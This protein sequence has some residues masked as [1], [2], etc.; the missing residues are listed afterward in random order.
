MGEVYAAEDVVAE[1]MVALKVMR[2]DS[3]DPAAPERFLREAQAL[4]RVRS[5]HVVRVF[6]FDRDMERALLFVAME[7]VDGEDLNDLLAHGRLPPSLVVR[8]M[9]DVA[10]ALEVTHGAGIIHRDLK[11]SNLKLQARPDGSVRVK[12]LDFGL[13]RDR[14]SSASLTDMGKAPGTLTYMPPEILDEQEPDEQSDVYSLGVI[15]YEMLAGRPPFQGKTRVEIAIKH[16]R[17]QP[18]WIEHLVPEEI[19]DGLAD[20]IHSMLVK[21]PSK[22]TS[23]AR[24]VRLE[25]TAIRKE[26]ELAYR[27]GGDGGDGDPAHDWGLLPHVED[28]DG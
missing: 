7:L 4:A 9:E 17:D 25:A 16:L 23:S 24:M 14:W 2:R 1:R 21:D 18:R 13:V 8:V 3:D 6:D 22:R 5:P 20:L 12:L 19:P 27:V 26:N 11:P 15:A 10:N 28:D